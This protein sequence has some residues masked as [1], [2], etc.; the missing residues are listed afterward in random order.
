MTAILQP[1]IAVLLCKLPILDPL[2]HESSG[3]SGFV[4]ALL[5]EDDLHAVG[6]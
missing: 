4:R 6:R 3:G 5:S 1:H 2:I